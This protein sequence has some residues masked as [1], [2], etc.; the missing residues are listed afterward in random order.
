MISNPKSKKKVAIITIAGK[1]YL[2]NEKDRIDEVKI[3]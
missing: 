1:E 2:A 3:Q